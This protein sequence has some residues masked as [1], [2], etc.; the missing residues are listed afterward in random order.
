MVCRYDSGAGDFAGDAHEPELR[1][2]ADFLFI[3]VGTD[4]FAPSMV[5]PGDLVVRL[6]RVP[7][8][9]ATA[10]EGNTPEQEVAHG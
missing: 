5:R 9:Q 6:E 4:R 1:D 10:A 2:G 7:V 3:E 8:L